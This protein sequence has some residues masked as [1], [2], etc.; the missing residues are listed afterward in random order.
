MQSW[1]LIDGEK[2]NRAHPR[3][4][5]IPS[6]DTKRKLKPGHIVKLGFELRKPPPEVPSGER[7]W[8]RIIARDGDKFEGEL[9]NT[10]VLVKDLQLRDVVEFEVKHV[11]S[12]E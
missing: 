9:D 7:M 10:P 12:V 11:L 8:V 2:M 5:E 3:T 6:A 4:F 1:K